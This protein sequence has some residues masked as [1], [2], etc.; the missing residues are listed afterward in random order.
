LILLN[1]TSPTSYFLA[2]KDKDLSVLE[3][4]TYLSVLENLEIEMESKIEVVKEKDG[5]RWWW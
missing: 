2:I 5:M 4:V 3:I 1:S